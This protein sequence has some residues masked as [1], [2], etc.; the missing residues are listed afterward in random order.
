MPEAGFEAKGLLLLPAP[1]PLLPGALLKGLLLFVSVFAACIPAAKGL[2]LLLPAALEVSSGSFFAKGLLIPPWL[3]W[4]NPSPIF[5]ATPTAAAASGA[6]EADESDD[7]AVADSFSSSSPSSL[8]PSV[9]VAATS[10]L[11]SS[12]SLLSV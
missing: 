3:F 11:S 8:S 10:S 1:G 7:G 9:S 4:R 5:A 2:L 12:S 6:D